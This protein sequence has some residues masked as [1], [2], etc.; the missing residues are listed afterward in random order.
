MVDRLIRIAPTAGD[1]RH[2]RPG[3]HPGGERDRD[4][5]VPGGPHEVL[6][7]LAVGRT[8][9][10]DDAGHRPRIRRRQHDA[11]G[12]D[13]HVGA[14]ADR[15]S[16]VGAGERRSVVHAVTDHRD[17]QAPLLQRGD[18]RVLVLR[19]DLGKDLIDAD[20]GRDPLG[21]LARVP[22]DHHDQLDPEGVELGDG[23]ACLGPDLV[24]QRQ[25][26][27]DPVDGWSRSTRYSTDA[28]RAI[29]ACGPAG[30][31]VGLGQPAFAQQCRSADRVR[32]L[33][34]WWLRRH[35]R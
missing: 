30:D 6:D 12:L 3:Q 28:P 4:H 8:R 23:L 29:H 21:D 5:V 19:Q 18:G 32:R 20:V 31:R 16:D 15:Q 9:Q 10:P 2:A 7:H 26:A 33:R 34:Q 11:G 22:G 24:L 35:G 25:R 1:K 17:R 27:D 13:R 14:G